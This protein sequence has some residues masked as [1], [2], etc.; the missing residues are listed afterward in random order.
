MNKH[1]IESVD[2]YIAGHWVFVAVTT[3]QGVTGVGESTYFI[4]PRAAALIVEDLTDYLVGQDPFRTEYLFNGAFKHHCMRDGA[5]MGALSAIDQALWDI[6]G[7]AL[8]VP[9]WELLGGRVRDRVRAILLIEAQTEQEIL[10]K[11]RGAAAEGLTAI[12]LK[13]FIGDWAKLTR[14]RLLSQTADIVMAVRRDLGEDVDIAVEIHRNLTPNDAIEFARMI[15]GASPYFIEDPILPYSVESNRY[16]ADAIAAPVAL[17]ERNTTIWEFREYSDSHGVAILRPDVGLA[18]ENR[19]DQ[20]R[21]VRARVLIVAVGVDDDVRAAG[22]SVIDAGPESLRQALVALVP[23]DVMDA[24][25]LR[26]LDGAVAGAIVDDLQLEPL[27]S[28]VLAGNVRERLRQGLLLVE[29]G[30]LDDQL[31]GRFHGQRHRRRPA[32]GLAWQAAGEGPSR[33][34]WRLADRA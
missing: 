31:Y 12:K 10:D 20:A 33:P 8:G 32:T 9:V 5:L 2:A 15:A 3:D 17:A 28:V 1:R 27:D 29:A 18:G 23:H 19:R 30:D 16:V 14:A 21:D 11:A 24:E 26:H 22:E 13:P 7:K 6:K 34:R 4:H 25:R